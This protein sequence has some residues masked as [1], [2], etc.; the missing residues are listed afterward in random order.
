[1]E[2]YDWNDGWLFAPEFTSALVGAER[3]QGLE[4]VRIPHTVRPLPYNYCNEIGRAHV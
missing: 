3:P 2:H 4:E 1:M